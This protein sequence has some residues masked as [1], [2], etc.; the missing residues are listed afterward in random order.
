MNSILPLE[1][2]RVIR[3]INEKCSILTEDKHRFEKRKFRLRNYQ[4]R[5]IR[6][7]FKP[8]NLDKNVLIEKT[9]QI[10]I[11]WLMAAIYAYI[12]LFIA[13][14]QLLVIGKK[15]E[16][17]DSSELDPN[18]LMGKIKYILYSF[19]DKALKVWV[20]R[21]ISV[22]YLKI[23]NKALETICSGE[24]SASSSGR[25]TTLG[26]VWWDEA[27]F[28]EHDRELYASLSPNSRRLILLS[29]ANGKNTLF[30]ALKVKIEEGELKHT[31]I[32]IHIHWSEYFSQEWYE[33]Q[34]EELGNDPVLIAQELDI[35]YDQSSRE[36]IFY[37]FTRDNFR[38]DVVFS[39][40][41]RMTTLASFDYGIRDWLTCVIMQYHPHTREIYIT[42]AVELN[43]VPF[44]LFM[45]MITDPLGNHIQEIMQKAPQKFHEALTRWAINNQKY[46]Y[47]H[48]QMTGDP[49]GR[50]RGLATGV[51]VEDIFF[52]SGMD[53]LT[54]SEHTETILRQIRGRQPKI[55]IY[56]GLDN[57]REVIT[58]W[59]YEL[60]GQGNPTKPL[61]NDQS[62]LGKAMIYGFNYLFKTF[63]TVLVTGEQQKPKNPWGY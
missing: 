44:D 7:I 55:F 15:E 26:W 39:D 9:R 40:N 23:T 27:A 20:R 47:R 18:T 46:Q 10:G 33:R 62:H 25:G 14:E 58:K 17:I 60:D 37:N 19:E 49:A 2:D 31:W 16:F 36:R 21:A 24:S 51:S 42:D 35:D 38:D 63:E 8:G 28:T 52:E 29:T 32:L 57:V 12:I 43:N 50:Q 3:F 59:P 11:S 4:V 54:Y 6:E 34:K 45:K 56:S 53:Y 22:K 48:V 61:H 30:Y 13:N 5:A 41:L 1:A